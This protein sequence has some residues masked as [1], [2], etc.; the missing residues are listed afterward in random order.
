MEFRVDARQFAALLGK[1]S[2]VQ[3][4]LRAALRKRIRQAG[5]EIASDARARVGS[6]PLRSRIAAGVRVQLSTTANGAGVRVTSTGPLAGAW[7]AER[8]WRHPVFGHTSTWVR[9]SGSPGYFWQA[10]H[11]HSPRVRKSIEAAMRE[12]V[13][14]L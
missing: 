8:G 12:A 3:P 5:E 7:Q 11:A 2:T 4:K 10:V 9:Q 6:G 13:D 14:S 1:T